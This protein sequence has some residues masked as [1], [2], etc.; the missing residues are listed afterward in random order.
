MLSNAGLEHEL[1]AEAVSMA[2]YLVNC[3]PSMAIN[4]KTPEEV[5][6]GTPCDYS[7]LKIF[8]CHAYALVPSCQRT[9]LDPRSRKCIFVGYTKGVK[10]YR[11][12]DP[13][14]HKIITSCDV[15]FDESN[16]LKNGVEHESIEEEEIRNDT[17]NFELPSSTFSPNEDIE[18]EDTPVEYSEV[19]DQ[20]HENS[21][22]RESSHEELELDLF[23]FCFCCLQRS[24]LPEQNA[25]V[26]GTPRL[27]CR[28]WLF[29]N[30][31]SALTDATRRRDGTVNRALLDFFDR[32]TPPNP[33]PLHGVSTSDHTLDPSRPLSV[34]LFAPHSHPSSDT[35]HP[36]PSPSSSTSTAAAS[37]STRPPPA[38]TTPSA[39]ASP[40]ASPPASS[41]STTA[42]PPSTP[43]PPP[44]TT[45]PTSS[46]GSAPAPSPTPTPPPPLPRRRQRRGQHRP[47]R[48]PALVFFS[49]PF[50]GGG[51]G[52]GVGG[53]P[54]LLR[55]GGGDG[56][57]G[58]A[59]GQGGLRVAGAVRVD[60]EVVPAPGSNRDHP[61]ANVFGPGPG[62]RSGSE[63]WTGFPSTMV[64]V[65]G[66]DPLQDRQ[67]MYAEG[68]RNAGVE[69]R[70]AEYPDAIHG[71]FAFPELP[72]ARRFVDDVADFVNR[73]VD[74]IRA[75]RPVRKRELLLVL[76]VVSR[77]GPIPSSFVVRL[78][79][80]LLELCFP[81]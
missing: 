72:E 10:G 79:S 49:F 17:Q 11:L 46:A 32:R 40:A 27:P 12:W 70:L 61:A 75:G 66:W 60:V 8:G 15:H 71:F 51:G 5:W 78:S 1:W 29:V 69:T 74:R 3:S 16:V 6:F 31:A 38:P 30:A 41:P 28:T 67:R 36:S 35:R 25:V 9:K 63:D 57:G 34:R 76:A 39:A 7:N 52:R 4:G 26:G 2:C 19:D 80:L 50:S 44:T 77:Q 59:V 21:N 24:F 20:I 18:S 53:D 56:V 62:S 54:A 14:A 23:Y 68:L 65:G 43:S 42:A 47:P 48:R 64:C 22:E 33:T 55:R 45:A 58:A 37:P 81:R 13:V 73:T